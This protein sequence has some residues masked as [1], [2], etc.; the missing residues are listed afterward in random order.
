MSDVPRLVPGGPVDTG[1]QGESDKPIV[2]LPLQDVDLNSLIIPGDIAEDKDWPPQRCRDRAARFE[3]QHR[4]TRGDLRLLLS[5]RDM[6]RTNVVVN[7]LGSYMDQ[8]SALLLMTPPEMTDTE[9]LNQTID[10]IEAL[11]RNL[12]KHGR[13]VAVT[14]DDKLEVYDMRY[15]WPFPPREDGFQPWALIEP[16]QSES[17]TTS[18]DNTVRILIFEDGMAEGFIH[19]WSES[20]IGKRVEDLEPVAAEFAVIDRPPTYGNWGAPALDD[21]LPLAVEWVKRDS[22]ISRVSRRNEYSP[23]AF[24]ANT[25]D[26][27]KALIAMNSERA[28][29][30][31]NM[32]DREVN[33][34]VEEVI[35][36]AEVM[37]MPELVDKIEYVLNT[38]KVESSLAFLDRLAGYWSFATGFHSPE[39]SSNAGAE[40]GVGLVL[41][42]W[43][44]DARAKRLKREIHH[45]L[46][47]LIGKFEWPDPKAS[48]AN[49]TG[50][51]PDEE[52]PRDDPQQMLDDSEAEG[53]NGNG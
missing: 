8:M 3:L 40:S 19:E 49:P 10:A 25:S 21:L 46:E 28:F 39:Q 20:K 41:M 42:S 16:Y 45:G 36:D 47:A 22:G 2:P 27:R 38:M 9:T 17:A 13:G 51:T 26:I 1:T 5:R 34:A 11:I 35:D 7:R 52:L 32:S 15:M 44:G 12:M 23:I 31:D 18:L 43:L 37:Y 29:D 53:Q 24:K 6:R 4:V 30:V 14:L 50:A 48:N 33:Q